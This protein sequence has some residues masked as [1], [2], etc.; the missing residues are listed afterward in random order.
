MTY[1]VTPLH[2][3]ELN[4]E[5]KGR[6][7]CGTTPN[8]GRTPSRHCPE[9]NCLPP[10]SAGGMLRTDVKKHSQTATA[11]QGCCTNSTHANGTRR[12]VNKML[13][14]LLMICPYPLNQAYFSI[15]MFNH[16]RPCTCPVHHQQS[17]Y[18]SKVHIS[19]SSSAVLQQPP[20]QPPSRHMPQTIDARARYNNTVTCGCTS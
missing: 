9:K 16:N 13:L 19:F 3:A 5:E 11:T 12:E 10:T 2:A 14:L 8:T 4:S 1:V 18:T 6:Y 17:D 20:L 15:H 7:L